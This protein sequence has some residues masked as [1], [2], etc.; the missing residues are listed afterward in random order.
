MICLQVIW[1]CYGATGFERIE[2]QCVGIH[3][4]CVITLS[5]P[6]ILIISTMFCP[7]GGYV[8]TMSR[9]IMSVYSIVSSWEG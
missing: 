4:A 1:I 3:I 8:Y 6:I 2:I 5:I 9:I 7:L